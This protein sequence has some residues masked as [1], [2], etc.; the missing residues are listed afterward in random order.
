M[1]EP[2]A[3]GVLLVNL[4]TPTEPTTGAV[5]RYLRQFL[6]DKRVINAPRWFWLPLLNSIILTIRP[7]RVARLYQKVWT[8]Q[9]SPLLAIGQRQACAL[10]TELK[11]KLH[12]E[13]PV[14][15]SMTYGEPSLQ[16]TLNQLK[17]QGIDQVLILPLYPQYSG[18][19]TAAVFDAVHKALANEPNI[20]EIRWVKSYADH[21]AY[22]QSLAQS[23][24]DHWEAQGRADKL[25][26]SFHGIPKSYVAAGD[27]YIEECKATAHALAQEL[28]LEDDGWAYSF[29]SRFG[30]AEW[31]Q[32][33]TDKTLEAWGKDGLASVELVCPA[34]TADCLETLE[35]IALQNKG[36]F[37]QAGGGNYCYIPALNDRLDFIQVLCGLVLNNTQG[38][39]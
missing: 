15:L 29:Q 6:S 25:L 16:S 28:K 30:P 27:P 20:P 13:V 17:Q 22:I 4:G 5:R 31:V 36:I 33:Y 26:M 2:T 35:E 12:V 3:F 32:P 34:F 37:Q 19:T 14:Y 1:S 8:E 9:G 38:W 24:R 23:V 10:A 39:V 18:T 11:Q 21:L 7:P